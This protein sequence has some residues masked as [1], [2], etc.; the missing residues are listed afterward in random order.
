LVEEI[1]GEDEAH[2]PRREVLKIAPAHP[3]YIEPVVGAVEEEA[4]AVAAIVQNHV[5]AARSS[6]EQ[7]LERFVGVAASALAAGD[8]IQVVDWFD[9]EGNV[10]SSLDEGQVPPL[11]RDFR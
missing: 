9:L 7:L 8:V 6:D 3:R 1:R 11:I 5:E 2:R 10:P 4:L